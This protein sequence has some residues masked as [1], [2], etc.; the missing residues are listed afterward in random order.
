MEDQVL[1]EVHIG[2][3]PHQSSWQTEFHVRDDPMVRPIAS[4]VAD[5][6]SSSESDDEHHRIHQ[7]AQAAPRLDPEGDLIVYR[8]RCKPSKRKRASSHRFKVTIQHHLATKLQHVGLQ[9]T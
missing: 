3:P 1:S 2:T 5:T 4:A 9:V 6:P 8:R 7:N